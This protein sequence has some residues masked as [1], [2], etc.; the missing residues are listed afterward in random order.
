MKKIFAAILLALACASSAFGTTVQL[1]AYQLQNLPF[2]PTNIGNTRTVAVIATNG[3]ATITSS[4]AFPS[5]MV[6]IGGFQVL[7]GGTQYVVSG[8]ASTSSMTLTTTFSGSTGSAT[9]TIYPWVT[10][11]A[12]ATAGFQ[13]NVTGQ[14]VQPGAPGSGNFYKQVAVSI[15]NSGSGNVAYLPAF[16]VP[17][18][19]DA[20]IN[21]QARYVFGFYRT[22]NSFLAFYQCGA[23]NQLAIQP[24]TPTT[25]TAICNFNAPGGVVPPNTDVYTK[26]QEDQM[27]PPCT[28]GQSIY[29]AT[30]GQIRSCLNFGTNLTLVG[31]TLNA[32]GGGGSSTHVIQGYNAV[33]DGLCDNTGATNATT[34]LNTALTTANGAGRQLFLPAG[35]YKVCGFQNSSLNSQRIFGEG[36]GRTILQSSCGTSPVFSAVS[37]GP[38]LLTHSLTIEEMSFVGFGSGASDYGFYMA[39]EQPFDFTMRNVRISNV[40]GI[41]V[42]VP[43]NAFTG[44]L[45]GVDV[46]V[47]AGGT[48]GIDI[49]GDNTWTLVRCYVHAVGTN[50]TAYRLRNGRFILIGCNGIDSGTTA[51]WGTFGNKTSEDGQDSYAEVTLLGCNVEAFTSIGTR[52]KTGSKFSPLNTH[53]VSAASGT[54]KAIVIDDADP[55]LDHSVMG[56]MDAGTSFLLVGTATWANSAPI[57]SHGMPF[58]MEGPSTVSYYDDTLS[59][60]ILMPFVGGAVNAASSRAVQF[61]DRIA[62]G[63]GTNL[64][65]DGEFRFASDDSNSIGASTPAGRPQHIYVGTGGVHLGSGAVPFDGTNFT[66]T[67]GAS[68]LLS[69]N[70]GTVT[71]RFQLLTG[72]SIQFGTT[73]AH[74]LNVLTGGTATWQWTS[75]GDLQVITG[76]HNIGAAAG[77]RP[78]TGY[79]STSVNVGTP[80]VSKGSVV[81]GNVNNALTQT[82]EGAD[83]PSA[84]N[85]FKWPSADPTAGQF[86]TA[87]APAAGIVTLSWSTASGSIGGGGTIGTIPKFTGAAAIGDSILTEASAVLTTAGKQVINGATIST[88]ATGTVGSL[89]SAA[90]FTKNDTN[91]RV[92]DVVRI[93]PTFNFGG[94]NTSTTVNLLS[95]D[96]TNTAV[97]GTIFNLINAQ[98]GG[99]TKWSVDSAGAITFA[100]GVR[101][102]FAPSATVSSLNIGQVGSDPSSPVNGDMVYNTGS[103]KFRCYENGAWGNCI[104]ASG[105][106]TLTVGSTAISGGTGGRVLYETAG[107]ALGEVSGATSNGSAMTF[108]ASN[109]IATSPKFITDISDTN[110]NELFKLTATASAVNEFTV[111]NAATGNNPVLSATGGDA[112]VSIVLT[113]KSSTGQVLLGQNGTS[114]VPALAFVSSTNYG[115]SNL[116]PG[117]GIITNSVTNMAH[118][119]TGFRLVDGN[120]VQWAPTNITTTPDL[121]LNRSAANTLQVMGDSGGT[122]AGKLFIA[123]SSKTLVGN[124]T[125]QSDSAN[126]ATVATVG[127]I[128]VDST[129]TAA[130]GFGGQML[131]AA[132]DS[133]T[134][135]T[136]AGVDKW[137]WR[138]ATHGSQ[139]SIVS[140]SNVSNGITVERDY[141]SPRITLTDATATNIVTI[142]LPTLT[143]ASGFIDY[144]AFAADG[145]NVQVRRGTLAFSVV[146]KA[147]AYTSESSIVNEGVSASSGTFTCT[148]DFSN[149]SNQTTLRANCDTS[150]TATSLYLVFHL[151]NQS[152]QAMAIQ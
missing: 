126:T 73:S 5:N 44:L 31:N 142:T 122:T 63:V 71:G 104:G 32:T 129:G 6:G 38:F 36:P 65:F 127:S 41:G 118:F 56:R 57:H 143:G 112:T 12:Y 138:T 130:A 117:V 92:F 8:V 77:N 27:N 28:A 24:G 111:A 128:G 62:L 1:S 98:Y 120:T 70:D 53:Y 101:Q 46:S 86:M 68:P 136:T 133:T 75:S 51:S 9:M 14:N 88:D 49:Y 15:I 114:T 50:G 152:E 20:L 106:V 40:A 11:R 83:T 81:Y 25:W 85:R 55:N 60:T 47:L 145:T 95:I 150:L 18:T 147:A 74:P 107:N 64:G 19:T 21:N 108:T 29:Y 52:A 94:S 148:F 139:G 135:Q 79:F 45:E 125:V 110:G 16:T 23:V 100:N 99:S 39:P 103:S 124:F 119:S 105:T 102:A 26:S 137:Y 67:G 61:F 10:L 35:T 78:V 22:D 3:S 43:T 84:T 131:Y 4:A 82:L 109:L 17:S 59:Q 149:G 90:T 13:D 76:S 69:F 113:P 66:L 48:N 89:T 54:L 33:V 34:C 80:G 144:E 30:N 96:S 93:K 132:E 7:L 87:S 115:F 58:I 37:G 151:R 146:N 121:L 140:R 116:G 123:Q 2:N 134:N 91:V 97:T 141:L 72:T 42:Y